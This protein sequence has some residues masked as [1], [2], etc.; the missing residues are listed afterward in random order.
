MRTLDEIADDLVLNA[1]VSSEWVVPLAAE[2]R[3]HVPTMMHRCAGCVFFDGGPGGGQCRFT[4]PYH[5]VVV[6]SL[7]FG[8]PVVQEWDWCGEFVERKVTP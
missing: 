5:A 7:V 4:A 3:A 6:G 1:D 2:V 8:W